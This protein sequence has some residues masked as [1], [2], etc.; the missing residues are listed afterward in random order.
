[1]MIS[2]VRRVVVFIGLSL[3]IV[4]GAFAQTYDAKLFSGMHWRSI[5][6]LRGGRTRALAGVPG[7]PDTFYIAQVNGGVWKTTDAGRTWD[8][9]FDR[10]PTGSIGAIAVAASDPNIIYAG[11]GEGLQR[12]DLSTGDGVYKSTDAGK[13]WTHLGLR[14]GQQIPQIAI[15]PTNP[16]RLFVAVLGHPYGPNAERGVYRSIDGGKTFEKVLYKDENTGANDVK[17]DPANPQI[18]YAGLW[19]ARQGPWEN[20]QWSGTTGGVFK[21]TDGGTT[22]RK[23]TQGFPAEGVIEANLAIAPSHPD[24]LY[25]ATAIGQGSGIF[26]SDDAGESWTRITTD[27]R[28]AQRI[29]GGDVPVVCVD[30]KNPDIVYSASVVTWNSTDG[31]KTWTGIRGAPGGDDYQGIWINPNQPRIVLLVS[32]QG[33]IVTLNGGE[34]WSSWYNQSTAQ[35]YHANADNAFPYRVCSGQQESGSACV[36]SRGNDGEITARE[37]HP[38]GAEEYGYAVP[39]PL[40]P[41]IVYG[42]KVT[43]YDRR[44][45]QVQNVGPK[46]LRTPDYRTVRTAPLVFSPVDPH[47]LYLGANT[48]WKT[49]DGGQNWQ[50][51]SPDL[52]RK[53]WDVPPSV[54]KYSDTGTAKPTQRGVIYTVAPSPLGIGRIWAG[55]DDG[56]I[57]VTSDGGAHWIDV[58]PP[59]ITAWAKVSMID[60]GHFDI[61]TAYAAVNTFRLDDLRPHLFRTHDGGKNWNEITQGIPAGASTNVVRED[62]KR[63]GLLYAGTERET[64][65]SFDDGDHW[66]TL[67]LNMPATSIRDLIVKDDDLVVATHGRGFWILDDVTPLRQME[68][69]VTTAD[70]TLFRIETATRIRWDMNTDT[71]LPPDEPAGENPP[72]GAIID[73]VLGDVTGPVTLEILDSA[74]KLVRRYASTDP[75]EPIDPMLAIPKYWVRPPQILETSAGMHRFLWDLHYQPLPRARPDYPMQAI[76]H[77]TAPAPDSPWVL[78]GSYTVKLTADGK[79]YTEP[80]MV[81]MDPRIRASTTALRAQFTLSKQVYDEM[82]SASEALEKVRSLRAQL[83]AADGGES[84]VSTA[85]DKKLAALQGTPRGRG[86]GAAGPDTL[87]SVNS[88]LGQLLRAMQEADAAPT[89]ALATAVIAQRTAL[90]HL[91]KS[92][93]EITTHDLEDVNAQRKQAGQPELDLN[94]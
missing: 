26:R 77:D 65:V 28:P 6:P 85:L 51:I 23:L 9:I 57:Q 71:P 60:A 14:D 63:K 22:W 35:M 62:P 87:S 34:S 84:D 3:G 40:D 39:D 58:T 94:K 69:A 1:M 10:E 24:R 61:Q 86:F 70:A 68:T 88:S 4:A 72:D 2:Q 92:W 81:K 15:D 11:S 64:Y 29:G 19:E 36:A 53:T 80:L 50:E 38:V 89:T 52:T 7:E 25:A 41:D 8:P 16:E 31:G 5:G 78:P 93:N 73:Y 47:T 46:P 56:L 42:G 18:V 59:Q 66:Q 82:M 45:G 12:P 90:A 33:A 55:T 30:P 43:R 67:R 74:G 75:V 21:S 48:L 37:W 76:V 32:D 20:A 79:S 91:M 49:R 44:T 54:G 83:K 17:L 13:T 27:P